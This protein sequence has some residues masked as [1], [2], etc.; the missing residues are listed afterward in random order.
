[1][2]GGGIGLLAGLVGIGGGIFLAPIMHHLKWAKAKDI[3]ATSSAFIF[4]N[5]ISGLVGQMTKS[6]MQDVVDYWPLLIAVL[7]GGQL[8]SWVSNHTKVSQSLIQKMTALLIL[9]ITMQLIYK[10]L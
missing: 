8:G 10:L 7:I 5:S 4:L 6:G 1:M 9:S 3:A 2:V